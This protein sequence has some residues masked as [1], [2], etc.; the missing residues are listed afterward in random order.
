MEIPV[1]VEPSSAGFRAATGAPLNLSADGP[2]PDAAMTAL[3][4]LLADRLRAGAQL[5]A[6]A[7]TDVAGIL[8][9]VK[10]LRANPSFGEFEQTVEEYRRQHN[11]IPDPDNPD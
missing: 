9:S 1:L 11:T 5:H 6:L 8:E 4:T 2:T 7:V 3:R 10:R